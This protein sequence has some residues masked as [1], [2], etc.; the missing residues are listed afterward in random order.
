MS[1][2]IPLAAA[3][4]AALLCYYRARRLAAQPPVPR[5]AD[6]RYRAIAEAAAAALIVLLVGWLLGKV[7]VPA[8]WYVQPAF[9]FLAM[10]ICFTQFRKTMQERRA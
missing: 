2:F 6:P 3:A 4:V 9:Q 5:S 1:P 8:P 10:G 7:M